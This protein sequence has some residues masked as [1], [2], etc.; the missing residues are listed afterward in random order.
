MFTPKN[1]EYTI[2]FVNYDDSELS[3]KTY[4]YGTKVTEPS[5]PT[6]PSDKVYTYTFAGW[7]KAVTT[8]AGDT[9]YK[10]TYTPIY[11]VYIVKFVNYDNSVIDA[12][13]Y[14]YGETVTVPESPSKDADN[15]YTYVFKSWDSEVVDCVGNATYKAT[16]NATYIDYMVSFK[17]YD[18]MEL[19]NKKY[20]YG[21]EV[22]APTTTPT[23]PSDETYD[24]IFK[25]WDS[26]V[27]ACDG[28][29]TYTAVFDQEENATYK[30]AQLLAELNEIIDGI[31]TVDLN[32]Y[33][34]ITSIQERAK[35]L[36]ELD[37]VKLDTKL[38]QILT[39]YA[40]YVK[41]I[42]SE[43]EVAKEV[44]KTYFIA[45]L[46]MINYITVLA[47]AALKGKRWFL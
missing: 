8:V 25:G 34:T 2:K 42:N 27:V 40:N 5:T 30:S 4:Y 18:G 31:T 46:E 41:S 7:D 3:S 24:Y 12:R 45:I 39:Q 1:V 16:Y 37:K 13:I 14:H 26:A 19:S 38:Q 35:D 22:T 20:H 15:T 32:T 36:T 6:K 21:D 44:E 33:S 17:N 11:I 43:Y 9:T 29:K 28:N 10:A 47:Y 23:K